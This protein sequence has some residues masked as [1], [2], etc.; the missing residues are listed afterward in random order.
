MPSQ[1]QREVLTGPDI[2][3]RSALALVSNPVVRW[4][5]QQPRPVRR[6]YAAD[7]LD[8]ATAVT[9][10]AAQEAWMLRNPD[11][12]RDSYL[13]LIESDPSGRPRGQVVWMLHQPASVRDSYATEVLGIAANRGAN[14]P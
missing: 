13:R 1:I 5:L 11:R 2:V 3:A 14:R 12:V 4:M 6:A 9:E 7:V 8:R 10:R